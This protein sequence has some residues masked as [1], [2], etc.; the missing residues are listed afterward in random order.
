MVSFVILHYK[1]MED[2][3]ECIKSIKK[4]KAYDYS[5]VVVDNGTLNDRDKKTLEKEVKDII[6][7]QEN[8]GFATANNIGASYAIKK[9]QPDFLVILNNDI[10]L[11]K[12]NFIEKIYECYQ[13]TSFDFMGP[14]IITNGGESV[15][16]FLAYQTLESVEKAIQKSKKLVRIYQSAL[17]TFFLN[18]YMKCKRL[19]IPP[20]HLENG[21]F[22]KKDVALHGC[23]LIFSKK[24]YQKYETIFY[25]G[26]FL[27]HEEEFLEYRRKRDHLISFYDASLEVFHKEGASLNKSF[28]TNREKL[29]FRNQEI[30]KS[31]EL[32]KQIMINDSDRS[33]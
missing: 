2:T 20:R 18:C 4:Q 16:P 33:V 3:L 17:L 1:N 28:Q 8:L 10:V 15:N 24:Y 7:N 14:K 31:L 11:I 19:F 21:E 30:I 5:I 22:S 29:I 25:P 23:C 12:E 6:C 9:Y 32:L 27:Y 13:K 26:T